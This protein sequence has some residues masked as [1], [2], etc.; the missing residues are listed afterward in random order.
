MK[1][2]LNTLYGDKTPPNTMYGDTHVYQ[3]NE[4]W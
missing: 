1:T 3:H 2:S 4:W